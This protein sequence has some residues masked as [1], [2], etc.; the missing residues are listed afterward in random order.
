MVHEFAEFFNLLN[1][2]LRFLKER[3]RLG[4]LDGTGWDGD[5]GDRGIEFYYDLFV[6]FDGCII[7]AREQVRY[8]A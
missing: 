3:R 1:K 8:D 2:Q 7:G 5:F 4:G 6:R